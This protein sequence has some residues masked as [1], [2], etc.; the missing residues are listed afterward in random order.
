MYIRRCK[1]TERLVG[2][3]SSREIRRSD[4]N[5][6]ESQVTTKCKCAYMLS[7]NPQQSRTTQN[8]VAKKRHSWERMTNNIAIHFYSLYTF[9]LAAGSPWADKVHGE[10]DLM[11]TQKN[12][13]YIFSW[14]I[15]RFRW[16]KHI[17][18]RIWRLKRLK[19]RESTA[20]YIKANFGLVYLS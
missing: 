17:S 4:T 14:M 1:Q 20:G 11:N 18:G 2:G 6:H 9:F 12:T 15:F 19:T 7:T 5:K 8:C 13:K 3:T 10:T 16:F